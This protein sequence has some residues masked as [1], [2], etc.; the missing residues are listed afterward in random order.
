MALT[1]TLS[2]LV[3]VEVGARLATDPPRY[4]AALLQFDP[5]LGFRGI[6]GFSRDATPGAEE[7]NA[8][9]FRFSLDDDG[10]RPTPGGLDAER[11]SLRAAFVGDSFLV[12]QGLPETQ[13]LPSAVAT[14]LAE[15]GVAAAVSNWSA[16]DYGTG[17]QLVML[18]GQAPGLQPD[19]VVLAMYPGNDVVNNG[20]ELAGRTRVSAGDYLRPYW[21]PVAS[22]SNGDGVDLELRWMHPFRAFARNH[23]R[24]YGLMER[25]LLARNSTINGDALPAFVES[26][27]VARI[28]LGGAP[29][30]SLEVFRSHDPGEPWSVAWRTTFELLR[31]FRDECEAMGSRF[32]VLLI[33]THSQV[34]RGAQSVSLDLALRRIG[35]TPLDSRLDWN[36]P[37]KKLLAFF[38][39]ERIDA[40]SLLTPLREAT[41]AGRRPYLRD[42][43]LSAA[44]VAVAVSPVADWLEGKS[45]P[46]PAVPSGAPVSR[47]ADASRAD[48]V[49][50][51]SDEPHLAWLGNG[52][53]R[54]K[55]RDAE[56]A[57]R[58]GWRVGARALAVI[59]APA[60]GGAVVIRGVL[61]QAAQGGSADFQIVYGQRAPL[62]L[63]RAGSFEVRIPWRRDE[64]ALS[65]EGYLAVLITHP[66]WAQNPMWI[67]SFVS[68]SGR[69]RPRSARR[70]GRTTSTPR[71]RVRSREGP[72]GIDESRHRRNRPAR[73][74]RRDVGSA[75]SLLAASGRSPAPLGRPASASV[76]HRRT[77]VRLRKADAG[78]GRDHRPDD[79]KAHP[80]VHRPPTACPASRDG[81]HC[82]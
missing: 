22:L 31:A 20:I 21:V 63:K 12:G 33:P 72:P 70:A 34:E 40:I 62:S 1:A 10:F 59:P 61:P 7:G 74:A 24:L 60:R 69:A 52:W 55:R 5:E 35:E 66:R 28:R 15:R 30:E 71:C 41:R 80:R 50:E 48:P 17:Q 18:R 67:H 65:S 42:G 8:E 13:V 78:A 38:G 76:R 19:A 45:A 79:G 23:S 3:L 75:L 16:I 51:F 77:S 54:W 2:V 47:L 4:H 82:R 32:L 14:E 29:R 44:G 73:R 11:A 49:V 58:W 26:D 6:P 25:R 68:R 57:N 36:L 81:A 9:P 39:R 27:T 46:P 43:H 56:A 53:L 37:E 64:R